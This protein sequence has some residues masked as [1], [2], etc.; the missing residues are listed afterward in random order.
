M[1]NVGRQIKKLR[2]ARN[3][4]QDDLAE[5]LFVSR[6]TVSNYETGK[7]NPDID[8]LVRIAQIFETDV[9]CLIYGPTV[10]PDQKRERQRAIV[11]AVVTA[12]LAVAMAFL[13][14]WVKNFTRQTF[15]GC[16]N[17]ILFYAGWPLL[18]LLAGWTVLDLAGSFL[19]AKRSRG[20][21]LKWVRW[22]LIGLLLLY[23]AM[24]VPFLAWTVRCDLMSLRTGS[25]SSTFSFPLGFMNRL[26]NLYIPKYPGLF[27]ASFALMGAGLW[28][29]R[30]EKQPPELEKPA[31]PSA[32]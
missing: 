4:T 17:Y 29:T 19:G 22:V 26:W 1:T 8:M 14:P 7:S 16:P 12:A 31:E 6:Q 25:V 3:M 11:V 28:L 32:L 5:Q 30:R 2:I 27:Q 20:K 21:Y 13:G 10:S 24:A 9:N 15:I 18:M 23:G